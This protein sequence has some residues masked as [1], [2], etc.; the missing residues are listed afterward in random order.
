M[1]VLANLG[2]LHLNDL[3]VFRLCH[4]VLIF[5]CCCYRKLKMRGRSYSY[6]PSPP[7]SYSRRHRSPSPRGRGGRGRDLP[8]SLLV[9]NLRHDCRFV[10]ALRIS[11]VFHSSGS[12]IHTIM[13]WFFV[14]HHISYMHAKENAWNRCM[15]YL[16]N[17]L[18]IWV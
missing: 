12:L 4:F 8:T 14:S 10:T 11:W 13:Y 2:Y 6:S 16:N 9:R 15:V 1:L 7:R 17:K 5:S 18:C 3:F